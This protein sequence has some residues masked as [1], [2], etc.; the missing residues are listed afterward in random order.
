MV[1][2]FYPPLPSYISRYSQ[3]LAE[4]TAALRALWEINTAGKAEL[5]T[6]FPGGTI[7]LDD[8]RK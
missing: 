5:G 6:F 4:P 8:H 7:L 2:I 3:I 1:L